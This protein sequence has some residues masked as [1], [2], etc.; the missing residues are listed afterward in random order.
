M[1]H[2]QMQQRHGA[3]LNAV[4]HSV[5]TM[6]RQT[7]RNACPLPTGISGCQHDC[8]QHT[9]TDLPALLLQLPLLPQQQ[10]QPPGAPQTQ[11]QHQ[12]A[13][14]QDLL[15]LL[16]LLLLQLLLLT[17][18]H[19]LQLLQQPAAVALHQPARQC[20]QQPVQQLLSELSASSAA[21]P[22][23]LFDKCCSALCAGSGDR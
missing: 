9:Q 7:K 21:A 15:L 17:V 12:Q 20:K 1:L 23:T 19:L 14:Q 18:Q 22:A 2:M 8:T 10:H 11:Q 13:E 5:D 3:V 4:H 16:L 6:S